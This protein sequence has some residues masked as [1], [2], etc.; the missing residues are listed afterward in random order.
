MDREVSKSSIIL[1]GLSLI[2]L[3]AII[4]LSVISNDSIRLS[5]VLVYDFTIS[6]EQETDLTKSLSAF[7]VSKSDALQLFRREFIFLGT[8]FFIWVV[9]LI[10]EIKFLAA[11]SGTNL[12][13]ARI[14]CVFILIL[15]LLST[16]SL[17]AI[18]VEARNSG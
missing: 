3:D 11:I 4:L 16:L 18:I 5:L 1:V 17:T 10:F 2:V 7:G 14:F 15:Q 13:V 8:C 12:S 6:L 9:L